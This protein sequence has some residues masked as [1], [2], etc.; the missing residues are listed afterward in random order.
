MSHRRGRRDLILDCHPAGPR[1][2]FPYMVER[3]IFRYPSHP[4]T[5]A[6]GGVKLGAPAV[7]PPECID[8]DLFGD[9]HVSDNPD[10]PLINFGVVLPV[11]R[12]E[13]VHVAL[14]EPRKKLATWFVRHWPLLCLTRRVVKRFRTQGSAFGNK[15]LPTRAEEGGITEQSSAIPWRCC[16][17]TAYKETDPHATTQGRTSAWQSVPRIL[18]R[19]QVSCSIYCKLQHPT[20]RCFAS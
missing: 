13:G 11:Q 16:R 6:P 3:T 17:V 12:F 7:D 4:C 5:K 14:H 2:H 18:A 8:K 10:C 19:H 9:A 20:G 15:R 1:A